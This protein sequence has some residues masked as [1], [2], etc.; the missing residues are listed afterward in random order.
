M[1]PAV[2]IARAFQRAR[3]DAIVEFVGSGRPLEAVI[4]DQAGFKR[5]VIDTVGIKQR[6]FAGLAEFAMTLPKAVSQMW[7]ILSDFR[8]DVVVGVGGYVSFLPVTLAW[9]R[10][11]P[12]WIHEA[13]R[14]PGLANK[15]LAHY[16]SRISVAFSD[17]EVPCRRKT[18]YTGQPVRQVFRDIAEDSHAAESPGKLLVTGGSQGARALD[19]AMLKL[20][21]LLKRHQL[22]VRHQ[23]RTENLEK[24]ETA[25]REAGVD[26]R[27]MDFIADLPESYRWCDLVIARSGAGTTMELGVVN[28]PC[29]LVPFPYAQGGHQLRN[30]QVLADAGK[31]II[32]EEG[33]RFEERL[34]GQLERLLT[35]EAYLAM[36][37]AP[38][39]SRS[40]DAADA[41][42]AGCL[43]L[44]KTGN[45]R[46]V[47]RVKPRL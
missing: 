4:I 24:L 21:P 5:H 23:C 2:D 37:N 15:V 40:L 30:A 44:V 18:V 1:F 29:I 33:A 45:G 47:K 28:R 3:A 17:A 7:R 16:A 11:I 36:R 41:I 32:V 46:P 13:E 12:T 38:F 19:E 9:L 14:R 10:G 39:R 20:I 43:K 6:G 22:S 25:Y 35:R 8:P 26:A 31:A 34:S 27:V 42:A